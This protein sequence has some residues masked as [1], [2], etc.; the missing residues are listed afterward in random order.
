MFTM[1]LF[2]HYQFDREEKA[3]ELLAFMGEFDSVFAPVR[4]DMSEPVRR[5]YNAKDLSE[6]SRILSDYPQHQSGSLVL[7]GAKY[8]YLLW[9]SWGNSLSS[10]HISLSPK[11]FSQQ[12]RTME[13]VRFIMNLCDKYQM[14]YG[15]GGAEEDWQATHWVVE[16]LASGS[17][18]RKKAQYDMERCLPEPSWFTVFGKAL[19]THF[20]PGLLKSLPVH[21]IFEVG[22]HM[23][24][25]LMHES[26]F[27]S[28][29]PERLRQA[30]EIAILLGSEYFFDIN[31]LDKV[32]RAIPG[33]TSGGPET[34]V[35]LSKPPPSLKNKIDKIE[36][37]DEF[38]SR[39][40][41]SPSST[42]MP[43]TDPADLADGLVIYFQEE[44]G[45]LIDY[46]RAALSK[47][48]A[49][50]AA[51][52]PKSDFTQDFLLNNYI[53]TIGAFLGEVLMREAGGEWIVREPIMKSR[54]VVRGK[55]I[56]PFWIAYQVVF[57]GA[58][59][60]E[61]YDSIGGSS[62]T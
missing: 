62:K 37:V 39:P 33:V 57:G 46:D 14:V 23:I 13:F 44:I 61:A 58:T 16:P 20:D 32:C 49:H 4:Y 60:L 12:E 24:G 31:D 40:V 55:E 52:P 3:H 1:A 56:D 18:A 43:Y 27:Q 47:A 21:Q 29:R 45:G 6:P 42:N 36:T 8:Q 53:P 50:F 7:K 51:H 48:D 35:K 59:L 17:T 38:E 30:H 22:Q 19:Q 25:M 5:P 28:E 15:Y 41:L 2:T 10:W 54:V 9:V 34:R 26:P 11:Y